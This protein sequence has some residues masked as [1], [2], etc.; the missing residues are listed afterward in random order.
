MTVLL[1]SIQNVAP[2]DME[3]LEPYLATVKTK[4]GHSSTTD[5]TAFALCR[6]TV[7]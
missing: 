1:T 3:W 2:K 7:M 6:Y 4:P 5:A